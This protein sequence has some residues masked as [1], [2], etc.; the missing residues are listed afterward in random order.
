MNLNLLYLIQWVSCA[1]MCGLILLIHFIH[2]PSFEL[3]QESKFKWFASDHAR[4][5]TPIV[6]P[7]MVIELIG[8]G[9]L[10]WFDFSIVNLVNLLLV[11]LIWM[12]TAIKS[13]RSHASFAEKG[14]SKP[15]FGDLMK[16]N[17]VRMSLWLFRFVLLSAWILIHQL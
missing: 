12:I 10:C 16:W 5:I 4:R 11:L 13:A 15:V 17:R 14:F 6:F 2:Y 8:S 7:A 1:W 3:I 9:L